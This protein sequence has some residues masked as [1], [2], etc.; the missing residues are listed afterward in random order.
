MYNSFDYVFFIFRANFNIANII[1][2]DL[3][4]LIDAIITADQ[5]AKLAA[6]TEA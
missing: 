4:G 6:Q 2:G 1:N 5:A 3:D